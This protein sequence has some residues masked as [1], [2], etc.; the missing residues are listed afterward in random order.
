M[1][2]IILAV[3]QRIESQHLLESGKFSPLDFLQLDEITIRIIIVRFREVK[4]PTLEKK[5][6]TF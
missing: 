4:M 3:R 5:R 2:Q 1:I 6:P